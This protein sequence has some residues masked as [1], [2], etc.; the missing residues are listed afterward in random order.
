MA[1]HRALLLAILGCICLCGTVIATCVLNNDLSIPVKHEKW[2]AQYGRVY[3]NATQ[4]ACR[5]KVFIANVEFIEMF[6][7]Q[8]HKSWLG[9]NQLADITND[10]FRT[11]NT[12]KGFKANS[13]RVLSSGFRYEN[14]SFEALP[15][16][17]DSRALSRIKASAVSHNTL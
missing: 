11:T 15:A 12:N 5:F 13:M 9:V 3:K 7:A 8:N 14:L 10:E 1:I 17:M 6:N 16:T 2:M 4:K